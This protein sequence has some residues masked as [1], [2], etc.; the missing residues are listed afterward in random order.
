M[1][2]GISHKW[3]VHRLGCMLFGIV[4]VCCVCLSLA[5]CR[6]H[7]NVVEETHREVHES[8]GQSVDHDTLRATS[9]ATEV[10]TDTT[11]IAADVY[12]HAVVD[13]D[14][15]GRIVEITARHK[16][17]ATRDNRRVSGHI[18]RVDQIKVSNSDEIAR[19]MDTVAK[20]KE[21]ITEDVDAG[22]PLEFR[23]GWTIVAA[24]IIFYTGDLIYR[25]W[26]KKRQ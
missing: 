23:I 7:R 26:K 5:A 3:G 2:H 10:R 22:I 9:T 19:T 4:C 15:A 18:G 8:V 17:T 12:F 6:S 16:A 13:R 25:Q 24:L 20:K 11:A 1:I 21:E 14:S